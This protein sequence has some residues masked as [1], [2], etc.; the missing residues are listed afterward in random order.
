MQFDE[1]LEAE[2]AERS[3]VVGAQS[4]RQPAS[5]HVPPAVGSKANAALRRSTSTR[6]SRW[7]AARRVRPSS[8]S[9]RSTV[10]CEIRWPSWRAIAHT[11]QCPHAGWAGAWRITGPGRLG[12]RTLRAL[13]GP[14]LGLPAAPVRSGMSN[15]SQNLVAGVPACTR[16]TSRSWK[17]P[18]ALRGVLPHGDLHC[19]LAQCLRQLSILRFQLLPRRRPEPASD[20]GRLAGLQE[21]GLPPVDGLLGHPLPPYGLGDADLAGEQRSTRSGSSS[22]PG[23]SGGF[24]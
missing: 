24:P 1:G 17:G 13:P 9:A 11:L 7:H 16:I 5:R 2:R 23:S 3:A 15:R 22:Q 20:Q 14:G 4:S 12:P 21:V 8:R 19:G 6:R 10:A 18:T